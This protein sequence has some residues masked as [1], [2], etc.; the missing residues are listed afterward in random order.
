MMVAMMLPSLMPALSQ[1]RCGL[2]RRSGPGESGRIWL[3]PLVGAGYF[4][5]WAVVGAS[6]YALG[7]PAAAAVMRWNAFAR[8]IPL[9]AGIV[10]LL[11]G[12]VQLTSWK[13]ELLRRCRD[14]PCDR[15]LCANFL[16]AWRHG[17]RLGLRCALCCAGFMTALIVVGVMDLAAMGMT[18]VAI[19]AERLLPGPERAARAA[20]ILVLAVGTVAI[21]HA[22]ST[23]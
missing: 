5:V 8:S 13:V 20:G 19:T 3:T 14:A 9:A 1:Y 4:F 7:A 6:V 12:A 16:T 15:E 21:V 18:T 2:N 10:L 11:A 23:V 22:I 17:L